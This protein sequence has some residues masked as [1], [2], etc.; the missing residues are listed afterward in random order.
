MTGFILGFA[1]QQTLSNFAA[2]F[3]FMLLLYR[4]YDVGDGIEAAGASGMVEGM[5]FV[6]TTLRTEEGTVITIPNGKI[7]GGLIKNNGLLA[8]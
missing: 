4:P 6:N 8:T 3:M 1:M 2:G 7:W 5:N